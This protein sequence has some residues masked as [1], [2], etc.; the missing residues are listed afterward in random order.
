MTPMSRLERIH[1]LNKQ[2]FEASPPHVPMIPLNPR[3]RWTR[4]DDRKMRSWCGAEE[5]S[6]DHDGFGEMAHAAEYGVGPCHKCLAAA[7]LALSKNRVP[8]I[9]A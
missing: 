6:W 3:D 5:W 8:R 1:W 9:P 7:I 4:P 2:A